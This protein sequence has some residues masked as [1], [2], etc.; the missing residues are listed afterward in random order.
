MVR[1]SFRPN[2]IRNSQK[3]RKVPNRPRRRSVQHKNHER[4]LYN[5]QPG[6]QRKARKQQADARNAML[7]CALKQR[8]KSI[9]SAEKNKK[10]QNE[11]GKFELNNKTLGNATTSK[12]KL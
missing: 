1:N 12:Q 11:L 10:Q 4:K 6:S 9:L 2:R 5:D 3:F 8:L 7:N